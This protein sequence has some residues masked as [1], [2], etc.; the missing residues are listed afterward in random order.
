MSVFV[1]FICVTTIILYLSR[2]SILCFDTGLDTY[3]VLYLVTNQIDQF[4]YCV[5]LYDMTS[6]LQHKLSQLVYCHQSVL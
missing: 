6:Q 3:V 2:L 1:D 4:S 5:S